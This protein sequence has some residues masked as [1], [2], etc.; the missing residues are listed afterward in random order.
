LV[1]RSKDFAGPVEINSPKF[2]KAAEKAHCCDTTCIT[3]AGAMPLSVRLDKETEAMLEEAAESLGTSKAW[4]IKESLGQYCPKVIA[5]RRKRPY[6]LVR[7]IAGR[8]GSGRGDLS[9]K[10][11]EI[12][13]NPFRRNR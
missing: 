7:D 1:E 5:K 2:S 8:R 10:S 9:V 11:E 4:V 3:G 6:Q 13:R 12:L